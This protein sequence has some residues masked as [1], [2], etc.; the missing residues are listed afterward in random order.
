MK[1]KLV[2]TLTQTFEGYAQQTDGGVENTGEVRSDSAE[3]IACGFI[4]G[5][6]D[7]YKSLKPRSGPKSKSM[8]TL[9]PRCAVIH[10]APSKNRNRGGLP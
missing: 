10:H 3:G 8:P 2:H 5:A 6:N 9:G 4:L 7:P 1:S